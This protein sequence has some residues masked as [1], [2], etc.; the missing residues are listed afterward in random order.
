MCLNKLEDESRRYLTG[1]LLYLQRESEGPHMFILTMEPRAAAVLL[2]LMCAIII[3]TEGF[4]PNCC[5]KTANKIKSSL[6]RRANR[7]EMQSEAGPCEIKAVILYVGPRKYC[8]HPKMKKTVKSVL[9]YR[10]DQ[11]YKNK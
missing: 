1:K 7:Y 11:N 8:L 3:T 2:L 4:I 5:I 9:K 10:L 6:L